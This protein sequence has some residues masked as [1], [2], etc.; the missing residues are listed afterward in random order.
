MRGTDSHQAEL[1]SYVSLEDRIPSDH[2]IRRIRR[3]VDKALRSI[4]G[5]LEEMYS[6]L[7]RPS[8][9]PERLLRAL[10]LQV[11]YSIRSE[12]QLVEQLHYNLLFRW[13]VGLGMDDK[14]WNATT[15]TKNRDRFLEGEIAESFFKAILEQAARKHLLS[16]DH[17]TVDGTLIDA[18]ASHQSFRPKDDS[19]G[20][21]DGSSFRGQRRRNDTH[22]STTDPDSRLMR[23]GAGK[24][25]KLSYQGNVLTENRNTLIVGAEVVIATGHAETDAALE[26]LAE[27][28]GNRRATV[29]ADKGYD[30]ANFVDGAR[31]LN[32]T[33][34]VNQSTN[35]RASRIDGRTT[36]HDGYAVSLGKRP[37][38]EGPIG[39]LK[40]YG[41]MRRPMFRGLAKM[42]WAFAFSA[43]TFNVLRLSN[44][45]VS[46]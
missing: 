35:G 18:W 3:I 34:H 39:W 43:A 42:R 26:M 45:T 17:F 36:R 7:G 32:V 37:L 9:A 20:D 11:L 46:A 13:F 27:I 41:L 16:R 1:F 12:R 28:E 19:G 8:I 40:Q 31:E 29:G 22:E 6:S 5:D 14:V 24:E 4:S 10:L 2:P 23:K 25:A 21:S 15:F 33:P 38:V 44:L 30:N